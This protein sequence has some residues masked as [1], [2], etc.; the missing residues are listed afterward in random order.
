VALLSIILSFFTTAAT[1]DIN[2]HD[3]YFVVS[4]VHLYR[5]IGLIF[6]ILWV[7]YTITEPILPVVWLKWGHVLVTLIALIIISHFSAQLSIRGP[8]KY[9]IDGQ[10]REAVNINT[11][12]TIV[13]TV[14]LTA[15]LLFIANLMT[16]IVEK[17]FLSSHRY[18]NRKI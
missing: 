15:Q 17:V 5:L 6:F 1:I 4:A 7:I 18:K 11:I 3:T 10:I 12:I 14:L 2:L 9:Y 8:H 13:T 16:G